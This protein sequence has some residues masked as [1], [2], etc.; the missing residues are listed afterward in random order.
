M[1]CLVKVATAARVVVRDASQRMRDDHERWRQSRTSGYGRLFES[2]SRS[3]AF[4]AATN[5]VTASQSRTAPD[6]S[7][8]ATARTRAF[9]GS[10]PLKGQLRLA[11]TSADLRAWES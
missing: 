7:N 10:E 2:A 3:T 8:R 6:E 4:W 9:Q 5:W 11:T 1:T